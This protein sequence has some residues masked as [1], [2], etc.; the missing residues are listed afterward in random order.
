MMTTT[1]YSPLYADLGLSPEVL[2]AVKAQPGWNRPTP[3]QQL[4]IPRLLQLAAA[5]ESTTADTAEG[6][7]AV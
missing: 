3:V 6:A 2:T 7:D 1:I 5:K 4:A